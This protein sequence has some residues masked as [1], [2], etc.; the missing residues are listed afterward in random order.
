MGIKRLKVSRVDE[1]RLGDGFPCTYERVL[2]VQEQ[3]GRDGVVGLAVRNGDRGGEG[4][5]ADTAGMEPDRD[6]RG[7][8][9][10]V[11]L[12]PAATPSG[13]ALTVPTG[14]GGYCGR[15][16]SFVGSIR[17][18]DGPLLI[19]ILSQREIRGASEGHWGSDTSLPRGRKFYGMKKLHIH[20]KYI[21]GMAGAAGGSS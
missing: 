1:T 15:Q 2:R 21:F 12:P 4:G 7:T 9:G 13:V 16:G 10:L 11:P 17:G 5:T 18:A 6:D 8:C 20:I 19:L 3:R 14:A